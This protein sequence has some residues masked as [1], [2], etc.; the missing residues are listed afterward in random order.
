MQ[1]L[2]GSL[3]CMVRN[4]LRTTVH[5][6][7]HLSVE[8]TEWNYGNAVVCRYLTPGKLRSLPPPCRFFVC[9]HVFLCK[10]LLCLF[11][12]WQLNPFQPGIK[13][14]SGITAKKKKKA[15]KP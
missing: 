14:F 8:F 13:I 15:K 5:E 2:K 7:L 4:M 10:V 12:V 11:A 3:L 1:H 6:S 9:V